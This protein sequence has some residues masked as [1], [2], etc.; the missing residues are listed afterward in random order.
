ME[1]FA[2]RATSLAQEWWRQDAR[3]SLAAGASSQACDGLK[4]VLK[5]SSHSAASTPV[6]ELMSSGY[7]D[8]MLM[9]RSMTRYLWLP[10]KI[11]SYTLEVES[12]QSE[13]DKHEALL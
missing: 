2:R 11:L 12:V 1:P 10:R 9:R 8:S 5:T 4:K 6:V 7:I 13:V 3:R